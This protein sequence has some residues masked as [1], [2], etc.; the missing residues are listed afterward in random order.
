MTKIIQKIILLLALTLQINCI[1][2]VQDS[3]KFKKDWGN[4]GFGIASNK[5]LTQGMNDFNLGINYNR[6]IGKLCYQIGFNGNIF[7]QTLYLNCIN[8]NVGYR[9]FDRFYL[10]SGFIGPG[11]MWGNKKITSNSGIEWP[12][13]SSIGLSSNIQV[14]VKPLKD[15]GIG[16]EFFFNINHVQSNIGLRIVIH[17]SNG[18]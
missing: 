15:L 10:L 4:I 1:G 14:I 11:F 3:T 13:Y 9:L 5:H 17:L 8:L 7:A 6:L 16:T 18:K 12:S 2:A